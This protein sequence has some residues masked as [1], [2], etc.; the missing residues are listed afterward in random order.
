ML[1]NK[2]NKIKING[3]IIWVLARLKYLQDTLFGNVQYT[4]VKSDTIQIQRASGNVTSRKDSFINH[5]SFIKIHTFHL[6]KK[7]SNRLCHW[8]ERL[9]LFKHV[10]CKHNS[11]IKCFMKMWNLNKMQL[12]QLQLKYLLR[13][14]FQGKTQIDHHSFKST[15][16]D[17][18]RKGCRPII[19]MEMS[20]CLDLGKTW[21]I[22]V[23]KNY[24]F[25]VLQFYKINI[26]KY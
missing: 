11:D 18:C 2:T 6:K 9:C 7:R 5:D 17:Y 13:M 25:S 19:R 14:L 26:I 20:F 4:P 21:Y 15:I 23:G 1:I 22:C 10:I 8:V 12:R 24:C 16:V 3:N